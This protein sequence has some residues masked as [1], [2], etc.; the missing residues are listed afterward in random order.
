MIKKTKILLI[1]AVLMLF[2][3]T[4]RAD[5][6][7]W[8]PLILGKKYAEMQKLGLKLSAEDIY[9]VNKSSLKDAVVAL[10]GGFC[11]GEIISKEGLLLTNHHCGYDAIQKFST[12]TNNYLKDGFWAM[13]RSEEI[14]VPGLTVWFLDRMEDVTNKILKGIDAKTPDEERTKL[15]QANI[16]ELSKASKEEGKEI[17]IKNMFAG[18]AY[19]LFVYTIYKDVRLVGAP[20]ESV[21]K[22]GGDTDNW[23][24]PRHTGDFCMFRVYADKDNN[25]TD[26]K[27]DNVP[28]QPKHHLPIS[29]KGVEQG[30]YAMVIGYPGS[31]NRFLTS[32]GVKQAVELDQPARVKIRGIKLDIMK[33]FMDQD[34]AVRIKY[35]SKY[36]RVSNYWKY[37]M[38]QS[39]QLVRN[40]VY[41]KKKAL[42]NDYQTWANANTQ[43]KEIYGEVLN[44]F[45]KAYQE[46]N[47][48]IL[49]SVY[50]QE[51][52]FGIELHSFIMNNFGIRSSLLPAL[53]TNDAEKIEA[54]KKD[55]LKRAESFYK[56]YNMATDQKTYAAM[57]GLYY[58]DVNKD[59]HPAGLET[60]RK[61][62]KSFE[63]YAAAYFA[64]SPFTSQEKLSAYL[65]KVTLKS[66][67]NDMAYK[68]LNDFLEVYREKISSAGQANAASLEKA[69][70]L[71]I[72]GL[73]QMNP[74]KLYAPDANS[75]MRITYGQVLNYEPADG[76]LYK[77]TTTLKGVMEKEDP[78][79][80][81][82]IVPEKLKELYNKKDY[83]QYADKNGELIVNFLSNNDITGGNSGSPVINGN[84]ELIGTAFDGNWEAMSG[85]IY[86]EPDLQRTI[87]CDIRFVLFIVDKYAGA[88][89]L[90]NEM[91]LVK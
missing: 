81:E 43:R 3:N 54:A 20:P 83:G 61:K 8:L 19:Y 42:E 49:A 50:F 28:Y 22:Y 67:E 27:E 62:F 79:N 2:G 69:N 58:N 87:S 47:K 33:E 86:F 91:T 90:V 55:I 14:H 66:I 82:F 16:D 15:I 5:E 21:G 88:T 9:S 1:A 51:A 18:N 70:R 85:D 37:F 32:Y 12:T 24:W 13:S 31:T 34:P 68:L 71:F 11:T 78:S 25:P 89:H 36:A 65:N 46:S 10:G 35:A 80:D 26:Y 38:G 44:T 72:D 45:D 75:T 30:D 57:L 63:K 7:M 53:K 17:R 48:T 64:K 40:K 29:L 74:D 60:T 56:D 77:H 73:H 84:G 39:E 4:S 52:I 6:G 23:M 59:F 41:D 76:V